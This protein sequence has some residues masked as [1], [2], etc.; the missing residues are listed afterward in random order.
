MAAMGNVSATESRTPSSSS[1]DDRS[2]DDSLALAT[3]ASHGMSI[4]K[5]G[6]P[7][8]LMDL[9][10]EVK[11]GVY[12]QAL[13]RYKRVAL[14][15]ENVRVP[16]PF[17]GTNCDDPCDSACNADEYVNLLLTS[18]GVYREA[19]PLLYGGNTFCLIKPQASEHA[20]SI[21]GRAA[22]GHIQSLEIQ[23]KSGLVDLGT[24]WDDLML[25]TNLQ[26][27]KL[28]FYHDEA[29]WMATLSDLALLPQ[30]KPALHLELY[31][32][33]WANATKPASAVR[34]EMDNAF[35]AAARRAKVIRYTSIPAVKRIT[36]AAS[37][38]AITGFALVSWDG[39]AVF[40]PRT[41][42]ET[43]HR[44]CLVVS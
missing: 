13:P 19:M 41:A 20:L 36:I 37:V 34:A 38:S 23:V 29:K 9:P 6:Q 18:R 16:S 2:D 24:I 4:T 28:V 33:V 43:H 11:M 15:R 5:N 30:P 42:N 8:R 10:G 26:Y 39:Q 7:F 44:V 25:C 14:D 21:V 40:K 22:L 3:S 1:F 32:S 17:V 27:L 35:V 31:T 12:R